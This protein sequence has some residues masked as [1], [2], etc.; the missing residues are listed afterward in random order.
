[1]NRK[2]L[3]FLSRLGSSATLTALLIGTAPFAG[4]AT[5]NVTSLTDS[6]PGSLRDT[7]AAANSGDTILF[8][9]TGT[10]SLTTGELVISKNL[11]VDGPGATNLIVERIAVGAPISR[12]FNVTSGTVIISDLTIR[13]G[14]AQ[15]D[16]GGIRNEAT[17]TLNRCTVSDNRTRIGEGG[18][19]YNS[20]TLTLNDCAIDRNRAAFESMSFGSGGGIYS[21]GSLTLN[22]CSFF[23]NLATS[24]GGGAVSSEANLSVT[25]C[26]FRFNIALSGG[27][28]DNSAMATVANTSFTGNDASN[29]GGGAIASYGLTDVTLS[30]EDCVFTGN[31]AQGNAGSGGAISSGGNS[32][33]ATTTITRCTFKDNRANVRGGAIANSG[34]TTFGGSATASFLLVN[35]TLAQNTATSGGAIANLNNGAAAANVEVRSCTLSRN[36]HSNGSGSGIHNDMHAGGSASLTLA[37]TS[38]QRNTGAGSVN[39]IATAGGV[40]SLGY[41]LA[42]DDGGGL[43]S[44]PGDQLNADPKLDPAGLQNN[45]GPTQS[46]ALIAGSPAIDRGHSFGRTTDQRGAPRAVDNPAVANLALGRGVRGVM[47]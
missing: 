40:A 16:G 23:N 7:I 42:D 1:M 29:G 18:G 9:V 24:G 2:I 35:C 39:L 26:S 37:N 20:G 47:L 14:F 33:D 8:S 44:G 32:A 36:G 4:A 28:I 46:F 15:L 25:S 41:N 6:G 12:V 3:C 11:V 30:V 27:A 10:I 21:E 22:N 34:N 31:E 13:R 5:L 19:I 45:G 43:L 17:L 38:L